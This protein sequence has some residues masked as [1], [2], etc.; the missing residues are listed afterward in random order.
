LLDG[1]TEELPQN[2]YFWELKAQALLENGQAK[3]GIPA[4]KKAR[5]LLP[6]SGLLQILHAQL[7]LAE[8]GKANADQA[9]KLI[10]LS[11][12]TES[13]SSLIFKLQAQAHSER[14]DLARA[15]LATAEYAFATGDRELA[16]EKAKAAQERFKRGTPEWLRA[17]DI[18]T[19]AAKK[20]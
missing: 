4:I 2:P 7:L 12:K 14:G 1:L 9:L 16:I 19:F 5:E 20:Q 15:E 10:T 3:R 13:D 17:N 8:G 11:K 6:N 18:L